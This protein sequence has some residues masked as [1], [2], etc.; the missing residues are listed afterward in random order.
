MTEPFYPVVTGQ[1]LAP[2]AF[3]TKVLDGYIQVNLINNYAVDKG[4]FSIYADGMSFIYSRKEME[5]FLDGSS[6]AVGYF[7]RIKEVKE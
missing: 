1:D 2:I 7:D 5:A 6:L 4:V 3:I